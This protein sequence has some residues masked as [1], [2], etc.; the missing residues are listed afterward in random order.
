MFFGRM[1]WSC[2]VVPG[3]EGRVSWVFRGAGGG[4]KFCLALSVFRF[5]RG[6]VHE[7]MDFNVYE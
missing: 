6:E 5:V 7:E 1:T 3:S 2:D 4:T